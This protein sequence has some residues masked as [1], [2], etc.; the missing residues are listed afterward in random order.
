MHDNTPPRIP[1]A[2]R[3]VLACLEQL[4][5]ATVKQLREALHDIR[6]MQPASVLT[7]LNRLEARH[8]VKKRKADRGKRFCLRIGN[9][10]Q[11]VERPSERSISK[12]V[13]RRHGLIHDIV[14]R[15]AE[16]NAAGN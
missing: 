14:L 12:G 16:A 2:E 13:R 4:G 6:P 10:Q 8:L 3:D 9:V 15:D 7:L 1:D 5:E 11:S